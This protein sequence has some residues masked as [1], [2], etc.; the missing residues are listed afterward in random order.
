MSVTYT[1]TLTAR[2][3]TVLFVSSMLH[4]ERLRRGTRTGTRALGCF[5][6]AVLV[7]RWLLDGTRL[8]QL[9]TDNAIGKSIAALRGDLPAAMETI[10]AELR[11]NEG[12]PGAYT[13][14]YQDFAQRFRE[15]FVQ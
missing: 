4:A 3:Q 6:Q 9:A 15:R 5:A 11:K 14:A 12:V 10:E 13:E 8:A 2:E 1:A 7:L